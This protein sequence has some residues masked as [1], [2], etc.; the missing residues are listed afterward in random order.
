MCDTP[1]CESPPWGKLYRGALLLGPTS[2]VNPP[3]ATR[4]KGSIKDSTSV[5]AIANYV[6][7]RMTKVSRKQWKI[8]RTM[9]YLGGLNCPPW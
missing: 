9:E 2:P 4:Q 6:E 7:L 3:R 5:L 1:N 8:D